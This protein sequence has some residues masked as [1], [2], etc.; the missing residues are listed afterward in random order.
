MPYDSIPGVGATYLDGAF[1]TSNSSAQPKILILG[2]ASKGLTNELYSVTSVAAAENEFGST[3]EMMKPLHEAITQGSDNIS[4]MRIGGQQGHI[5]IVDSEGGSLK[6]TPEHRDDEILDKYKLV[7]LN[8]GDGDLRILVYDADKQNYVYDSEEIEVLDT[9]IVAVENNDFG[10]LSIGDVDTIDDT[11]DSTAPEGAPTFTEISDGTVV[12]GD[13]T[14]FGAFSGTCSAMSGEAGDDGTSMSL[15]ERYAALNSA[16]QILDYRDGDYILPV[17]VHFDAANVSDGSTP[18][19][20]SGTPAAGSSGDVLGYVWEYIYRGKKYTYMSEVSDLF[21]GSYTAKCTLGGSLSL[22]GN[23]ADI[24]PGTEGEMLEIFF[25]DDGTAVGASPVLSTVDYLGVGYDYRLAVQVETGTT[26]WENIETVLTG[27]SFTN[28]ASVLASATGTI[29]I[30]ADWVHGTAEDGDELGEPFSLEEV[31]SHEE[32]TGEKAPAGVRVKFGAGEDAELREVNFGHQLASFCHHA[33]T[34]WRTMIGCISFIGPKAYDRTTVSAWAGELPSYE[35]IN[36]TLGID[37]SANDGVGIAGSKFL[38]GENGY[39]TAMIDDA[40]TEGLGY[41]GLILTKG[42]SL[43]N[44]LPYGIN[45]DDEAE[46]ANGRPVDI[47]RHLLVTYDHPIVSNSYDGGSAYRSSLCGTLAGKL[48]VT[49]VNEEPIGVNGY[50]RKVA[51]PPRMLA[52]QQNDLASI[53]AIG[54]RRE[55]GLGYILVSCRTAAHPTSDYTRLSTIRSVNREIEG[56]RE[57][58][59]SYIGKEFSSTR[60]I[61]LQS[62]IDGFLKAEK[63]QGY[64]QGALAQLSY[65]RA[66]KIMGRLTIK[67]KMIPPFSIEAITIETSLAAEEEELTA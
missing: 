23:G 33:S 7:L 55:E 4:V 29:A 17:G 56:I 11:F 32:L 22:E 60:L 37:G 8:N 47:G 54:L 24:S 38:A 25:W 20:G 42:G 67:L 59:K 63:E 50:V 61:S 3:S 52:P 2:T 58:A 51:R 12:V 62:A 9:G 30:T 18:D 39:R 44:G 64:N 1:R 21:S 31:L 28:R 36:G 41:G 27:V 10:A 40:T 43:P 14:A 34:T 66:D 19:Y 48:A 13:F 16:Y 45:D 53:R 5:K 57:I 15:A 49:P 26:T 46:D 6:I 65:T 35:Y